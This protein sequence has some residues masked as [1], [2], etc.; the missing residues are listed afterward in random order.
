M[1]VYTLFICQLTENDLVVDDESF[2][3]ETTS[4]VLSGIAHVMIRI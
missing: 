3:V 1:Q 4:S 2:E